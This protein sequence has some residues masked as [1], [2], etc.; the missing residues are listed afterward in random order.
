M[1]NTTD[2]MKLQR[3]AKLAHL[4]TLALVATLMGVFILWYVVLLPPPKGSGW[5]IVLF[6]SIPLLLFLPALIKQWTRAYIWLCFFIMLYFCQGVMNA[7]L[8]PHTIGW[9]GLAQ[10]VIVSLLFIVSMYAARW[11]KQVQNTAA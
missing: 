6:H 9:L 5:E 11:V 3:K 7:F 8:M 2:A 4:L 1:T 10:T